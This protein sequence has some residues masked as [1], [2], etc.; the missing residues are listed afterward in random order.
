MAFSTDMKTKMPET[1]DCVEALKHQ[2]CVTYCEMWY[3]CYS[4]L[5]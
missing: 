2:I 4:T 1:S 5:Y 3:E